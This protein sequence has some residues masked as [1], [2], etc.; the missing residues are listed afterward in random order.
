MHI[1]GLGQEASGI[2]DMS[3]TERPALQKRQVSILPA[4]P[5]GRPKADTEEVTSDKYGRQEEH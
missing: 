1:V 2:L 4:N 5:E 3:E